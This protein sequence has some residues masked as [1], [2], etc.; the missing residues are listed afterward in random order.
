[1][2]TWPWS[3]T[4]LPG[5]AREAPEDRH[6]L[7]N[8][9]ADRRVLVGE[10]EQLQGQFVAVAID[11]GDVVAA[12]QPVEHPVD[13]VRRAFE[14]LGDL[15]LGQALVGGG[16][17]FEDVE[18]LVERRRAIAVGGLVGLR[19]A[20]PCGPA[21]PRHPRLPDPARRSH[22]RREASIVDAGTSIRLTCEW[23]IQI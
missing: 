4:R 10:G 13:L 15:R 11:A 20:A 6:R 16:E 14:R 12:H 18:A 1:M 7:R 17:Q 22:C 5:L 21:T 2:T 8:Q 9:A 19:R 23:F 3:L